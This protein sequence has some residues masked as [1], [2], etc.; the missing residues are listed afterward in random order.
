MAQ[1]WDVESRF[2]TIKIAV[3]NSF[4]FAHRHLKMRTVGGSRNLHIRRRRRRRRRNHYAN[5]HKT[6][7]TNV[8]HDP[9]ACVSLVLVVGGASQLS[10][11]HSLT[12]PPTRNH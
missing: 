6:T 3:N 4:F 2:P 5:I 7:R 11:T 1:V 8:S 9:T 12:L 10:L